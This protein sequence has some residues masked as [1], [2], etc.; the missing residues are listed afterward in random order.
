MNRILRFLLALVFVLS[1]APIGGAQESRPVDRETVEKAKARWNKLPQARRDELKRR[2]KD[3]KA[4]PP[5]VRARLRA[6]GD[7]FQRMSAEDRQAFR[8]KLAVMTPEER[9]QFFQSTSGIAQMPPKKRDL[10]MAL[11]RMMGGLSSEQRE[12]VKQLAGPER[13]K[14]VR[15]MLEQK[16]SE[17]FLAT[18]EE[19]STFEAAPPDQRL[20]KMRQILQQKFKGSPLGPRKG[21]KGEEK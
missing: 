21:D 11:G 16:F 19:R 6:N 1:L 15:R 13:E 4:L 2:L 5:E 8:K 18:P 7:R 14:F 9:R 3:F 12:K 20:R 10:V 17:H